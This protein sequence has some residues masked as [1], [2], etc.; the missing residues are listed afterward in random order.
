MEILKDLIIPFIIAI[1]GVLLTAYITIQIQYASTKDEAINSIKN[2]VSKILYYL[3]I[4]FV[5][6]TLGKELS[7]NEPITRTSIIIMIIYSQSLILVILIK[8]AIFPILDIL[9][10]INIGA[11]KQNE[12]IKNHL[13]VTQGILEIHKEK[14]ENLTE[15]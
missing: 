14:E 11:S 3:W 6:Y 1:S 12:I 8:T 7:S 9:T 2:I 4:V 15:S 5:I 13:N 10:R